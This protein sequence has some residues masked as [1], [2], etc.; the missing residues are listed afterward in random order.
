MKVRVLPRVMIGVL[1]PLAVILACYTALH[2]QDTIGCLF[3]NVTGLYCPGC[4]SGR[5][6][7]SLLHGEI[8]AAFSYNPLAILLGAPSFVVFTHE[9]LRYVFPGLK[10]RPVYIS[11]GVTLA[12]LI[13][14]TAFWILRNTQT[15]SFLAP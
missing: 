6:V 10:L 1:F 12:L 9:Y 2:P 5:A 13:V 3:F 7:S 14:I 8:K 4:G 15:F 11:R